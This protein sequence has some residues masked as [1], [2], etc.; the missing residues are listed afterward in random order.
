MRHTM[1]RT[2]LGALFTTALVAF[3]A[4]AQTAFTWENATELSLVSTGGNASSSSLGLK[5]TLTGTAE[6]NALKFEVGGIRSETDLTTR[7][8]TGTQTDFTVAETTV[9][10]ITAENYFLR[11]RYDRELAAAYGFAGAGWA[12]NTFAGVKNRYAFVAGLGRT[13]VDSESGRFKADVGGTY[14]I[15]KDVN[16][17]PDANDA[18]GGARLTIDATRT[19][20]ESTDFASELQIDQNLEDT[21]DTR[22]DWISSLTV[23]LNERLAF[24]TSM[25]ILFDSQPSLL[26]VPLVDGGGA[27]IGTVTTPGDKVDNILTLTL[28]IKL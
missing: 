3:P 23:A 18:F 2:A 7:V 27:S 8:A 13:F 10:Q 17:A 6:P 16:P 14:T 21:D 1:V 9:S 22:A 28:V 4:Q 25:Q 24:K 5:A 11:G 15:Q 19:V 26:S 12:R 20:S